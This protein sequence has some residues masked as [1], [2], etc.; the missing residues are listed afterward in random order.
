L[1]GC[2]NSVAR[3]VPA[4]SMPAASCRTEND[5]CEATLS[6][7]RA[8]NSAI[9]C[10]IRPVVE[11][12]KAGIDRMRHAVDRDVDGVECPPSQLAASNTLTA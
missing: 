4:H 8:S 2:A 10:G 9:R 6:T 1:A 12:Q 5:I 11:D 7:P 3:L